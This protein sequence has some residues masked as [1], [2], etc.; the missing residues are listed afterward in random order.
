MEARYIIILDKNGKVVEKIDRS[1]SYIGDIL[2]VLAPV[3]YQKQ[4]INLAV[5]LEIGFSKAVPY[6]QY[7]KQLDNSKIRTWRRRPVV[8]ITDNHLIHIMPEIAQALQ[9]ITDKKLLTKRRN[10]TFFTQMKPSGHR[11][12]LGREIFSN[13]GITISTENSPLV[14]TCLEKDRDSRERKYINPL[15][16]SIKSD[17]RKMPHAYYPNKKI[18]RFKSAQRIAGIIKNGNY[19]NFFVDEIRRKLGK[20]TTKN[21]ALFELVID[22]FN[23]KFR[24]TSDYDAILESLSLIWFKRRDELVSRFPVS[25]ITFPKRIEKKKKYAV[26]R[27]KGKGLK[28]RQAKKCIRVGIHVSEKVV[29]IKNPYDSSG[30]RVINLSERFLEDINTNGLK[31]RIKHRV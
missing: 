27:G 29:N 5:V 26:T 8:K 19:S 3:V 18:K 13:M 24:E 11:S 17:F 16:D 6:G 7:R 21:R 2:V 15:V 9:N 10:L 4:N 20:E 25:T 31:S 12:K 30:A 1:V 23:L 28:F 14:Y 22:T